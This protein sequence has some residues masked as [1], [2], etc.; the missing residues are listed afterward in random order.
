MWLLKSR[1]YLDYDEFGDGYYTGK[2]Y[3]FMGEQYAVCN[4]DVDKAKKYSSKKRAENAA[5]AALN[6]F[7]NYVFDV[8][9]ME[10]AT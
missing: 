3:Q 10:E 2:S 1:S 5:Q 6:N 9:P 4:T 7:C 8:V